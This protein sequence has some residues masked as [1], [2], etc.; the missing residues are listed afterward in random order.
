ME[1][2]LENS[3]N[4]KA[5]QSFDINPIC[6]YSVT[7]KNSVNETGEETFGLLCFAE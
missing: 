4:G 6:V 3:R 1:M 7:G 2:I 5:I